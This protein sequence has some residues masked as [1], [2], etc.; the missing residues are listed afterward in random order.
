LLKKIVLIG[1]G[2]HCKSC[3]EV[4]HSLPHYTIYG[5]LDSTL[6]VGASI[7]GYPVLGNDLLIPQLIQEGCEFL[8]TIG[9]LDTPSPR[10][11]IFDTIKKSGGKLATVIASTALVSSH[12]KIGEGT[13]VMHGVI[14][15]V[16]SVIGDNCIINTRAILEH[17]THVS[18]HTHISTN[19]VLNG[20]VHV[21]SDCFIGSS[22]VVVHG[23]SITDQVIVGANATVVSPI[24]ESSMY[25]GSPAKPIKK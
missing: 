12:A 16:D 19:V 21:G 23:I 20:A 13:I 8:I 3:M 4:I 24:T 25:V 1:G 22:S 2:G 15:N 6:P 14:V 17:D 7:M 10:K 5:V 11:I 18:A 9:K